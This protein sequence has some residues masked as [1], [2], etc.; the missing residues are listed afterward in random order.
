MIH[1]GNVR[2]MHR[3]YL[4]IRTKNCA[5]K[6]DKIKYYAETSKLFVHRAKYNNYN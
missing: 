3:W 1:P 6:S 5:L 4:Q 2:P